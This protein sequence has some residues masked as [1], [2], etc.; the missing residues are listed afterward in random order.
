MKEKIVLA[1]GCRTPF[2]RS[3]TDFLNTMTYELGQLAIKGLL[4]KTGLSPKMVDS[5]I[6]GCVISTLKTSNLAR[7][8]AL[9]AGIP[10][11]TPCHTVSQACISANRAIA[12]AIGEIATGQSS[13]V[14]AGGADSASETPIGYK[15]QMRT[16]LMKG[17]K[18]RSASQMIKYALGFRLKDFLPEVPAISEYTTSRTMGEDCDIMVAKY[19]ITRKEQDLFAIRSHDNAEKAWQDG[20]HS[21]EV[22]AVQVDPKFKMIPKDNGIRSGSKPEKLAKLRPAF[23]KKYGTLT[24]ANSSFLSD[25]GAVCLLTT[26]AKAKELGL[27]PKAEI[28]DYCF[29]GQ[30]LE[31]ELLLGPAFAMSKLLKKTKMNLNEIDVFE[32]H[33]AFAGQVLTN[34][35]CLND[36]EFCKTRLNTEKAVGKI[37]INKVNNWGGSLSI[38][39]PFGAT[40]ARLLT[41][42]ANRLIE[43]NGKFAMLSACAAGAHGHAMIIKKYEA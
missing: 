19:Q 12:S 37:D 42:A 4:N 16:K 31:D 28:I 18:I 27:K 35:K 41:T 6:M 8:A 20:H 38:G 11:S 14:I 23:D 39:H 40:G 24:A 9:T 34:L 25:G 10:Y 5:V 13:V 36:E 43:E 1:D 29:T 22:V 7:E 15:K 3:E 17:T 26:E 30:R 33:E 32:I 21:K 2:L